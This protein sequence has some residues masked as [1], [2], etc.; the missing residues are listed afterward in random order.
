[1]LDAYAILNGSNS[2]VF[3]ATT[4]S[5]VPISDA[6]YIAWLKLGNTPLNLMGNDAIIFQ[7]QRLEMQQT[8]RRCREAIAGTDGGF[9]KAIDTKIVSLRSQL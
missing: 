1:M 4:A 2:Q 5:N 8:L 7:I 3:C 9:L 6:A